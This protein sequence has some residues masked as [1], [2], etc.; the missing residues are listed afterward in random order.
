MEIFLAPRHATLFIY[1]LNVSRALLGV[2]HGPVQGTA[3]RDDRECP[4]ERQGRGTSGSVH[5]GECPA[6]AGTVPE[7][8]GMGCG[9]EWKLVL[10]VRVTVERVLHAH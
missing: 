2:E 5:A 8:N 1:T 4:G 3:Y 9:E 7:E 6:F 10:S